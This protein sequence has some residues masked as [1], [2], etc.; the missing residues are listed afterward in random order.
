[1]N[2]DIAPS[3]FPASTGPVV[4]DRGS[5][6]ERIVAIFD[7]TGSWEAGDEESR[8]V[9]GRLAPLWSLNLPCSPDNMIR[10]LAA[11][12]SSVA[13]VPADESFGRSGFTFIGVLIRH[14]QAFVVSCGSYAALHIRKGRVELL[15]RPLFWVD[16]QIRMET[17]TEAE[18]RSHQLRHVY[19]GPLV[20]REH[21]QLHQAGPIQTG[22]IV[23]STME[24]ARHLLRTSVSIW[25]HMSAAQLQDMEHDGAAHMRPVVRLNIGA[26]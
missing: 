10:D 17:I 6:N 16:E 26:A 21:A 24:L 3:R 19:A 15:Y 20:S 25:S 23:L 1:M 5:P 13:P 12:V 8:A 11:V 4:V 22:T 14:E 7:G 2:V 9:A 18:A